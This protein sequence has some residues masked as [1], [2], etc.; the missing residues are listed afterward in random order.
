MPVLMR[1]EVTVMSKILTTEAF[2]QRVFN[3]YGDEYTVIGEYHGAH[4]KIEILHKCGYSYFAAPTNILNGRKCPKCSKRVRYTIDDAKAIFKEHQKTLLADEIENVLTQMPF[5]CDLHKSYGIQYATLSSVSRGGG[6]KLCKN[7]KVRKNQPK[8]KYDQKSVVELF[9][10]SHLV[11]CGKYKSMKTPISF[12]CEKHKDMGIQTITLNNFLYQHSSCKYCARENISRLKSTPE[13]EIRH[14]LDSMNLEYIDSRVDKKMTVSFVCK[15][16]RAYGVQCNSLDKI[17]RGQGCRLCSAS[18][19]ETMVSS[20]LKEK[21][22]EYEFQKKFDGLVGEGRGQLSYDFYLPKYN[23]L[24]E[25]QGQQHYM[26]VNAF[27]A[28]DKTLKKQIHHDDLKREYAKENNISL[29][30]VPYW[31]TRK[32]VERLIA[33]SLHMEVAQ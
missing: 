11:V 28:T 24:I 32:K 33:N 3:L 9:K 25:Y 29:I 13:N 27:H 31:L 8:L 19:G 2:K 17:K 26:I 1:M 30:E 7:E 15:A 16:H 21:N 23:T 14:L 20:I 4:E 18:T 10:K 12:Y 22:I 5:T 6:C